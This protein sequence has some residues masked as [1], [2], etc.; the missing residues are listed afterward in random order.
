MGDL[1]E[2]KIKDLLVKDYIG[3][4]AQLDMFIKFLIS[5]DDN[6][7]PVFAIDSSWGSGKTTFIKH[8]DILNGDLEIKVPGVD[9]TGSFRDKFNTF[10]FNAWENDYIDDPLQALVLNM[11]KDLDTDGLQAKSMKRALKSVDVAGFIKNVTHEGIDIAKALQPEPTIKD[12]SE[13][14]DRK[15]KTHKL[16]DA[17]IADTEKRLIFIIDEL[18]RCKPSFAVNLLEII[19]HYFSDRN[20]VFVLAVD[21]SQ[22]VHTVR[23]YYGQGF[24]AEAYLNRF[25]DYTISLNEADRKKYLQY[26]LSIPDNGMW[27]HNIPADIADH[28]DMSMREIETYFR[29]LSLLSRYFD[30]NNHWHDE[31][32]SVITQYVFVPMALALKIMS[33]VEYKNLVS[34]K[35]V[36]VLNDFVVS[37]GY[38]QSIA[39]RYAKDKT[40]FDAVKAAEYMR[41]IYEMLYSKGNYDHKEVRDEFNEVVNLISRY[42]TIP[43]PKAPEVE[44]E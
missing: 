16:L 44:D 33:P 37:S 39:Q 25:F 28:L 17:Y 1:S 3:R 31:A 8:L 24:N 26:Y 14:L 40:D 12:I 2:D 30:R 20:V 23:K 5:Q 27:K 18:D 43:E 34:G 32:L 42:S 36:S 19:K 6:V 21:S 10:Y 38:V 9:D 11:I 41:S 29:S 15:E 35:G 22:L 13:L 4:N 7:S